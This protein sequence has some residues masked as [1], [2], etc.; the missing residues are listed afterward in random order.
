LTPVVSV[1]VPV[2]NCVAF[3]DAAMR[4]ILAQTFTDFELLVSDHTSTDGTWEALQ[5]YTADPRV[6]LSRLPH[7]GGA[8]ANYNAVTNLATGTF[9]KLVCG[10][11]VLYPDSLAVQVA[12]LTE[13]PS[14]VVAASPR[15]VIDAAGRVVMRNRGLAGLKGLVAGADAIRRTALAG[16]N[17]F[18]EPM[19]V[20]YRRSALVDAGGWD[21]HLQCNDILTCG[22]V[23]LR[24]DLV[25]VPQSLA[26]FRLSQAQWSAQ[27]LDTQSDHDFVAFLRELA[28]ANPGLLSRRHLFVASVKARINVLGRRAVYHWLGRRLRPDAAADVQDGVDNKNDAGVAAV[29]EKN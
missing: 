23:L 27:L 15:D 7:G 26:A 10:D 9:L 17:I 13:H 18:G 6:R 16:T 5:G 21:G 19:C 12:A 24:G 22:A 20:L 28:V 25:A 4:S 1:V 2:Y 8:N 29:R 11:D 3:I 14:A